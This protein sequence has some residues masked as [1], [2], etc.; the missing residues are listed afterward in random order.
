MHH[1]WCPVDGFSADWCIK[2]AYTGSQ[3]LPVPI[4]DDLPK[5]MKGE[6]YRHKMITIP[7]KSKRVT[8]INFFQM[9]APLP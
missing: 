8:V 9:T 2:G 1:T 5:C 6:N 4:L 3:G 7:T